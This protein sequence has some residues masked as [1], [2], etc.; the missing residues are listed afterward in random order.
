VDVAFASKRLQQQCST[1]RDRKK[2]F[3][4]SATQLNRRLVQLDTA[5]CLEDMHYLPGHCHELS[6]DR[7]GQL[8]VDIS[9]NRR[10]IFCPNH[11]PSPVRKDGGLDWSKVTKVLVLE[12]EDY[13]G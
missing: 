11:R 9:P 2:A 8:A 12:V 3:G 7:D 1:E 13:H 10:L 6:A 4:T 5:D